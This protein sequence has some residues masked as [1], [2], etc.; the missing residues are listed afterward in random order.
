MKGK[1]TL[2][3]SFSYCQ[4]SLKY[5]VQVLRPLTPI[6]SP[7]NAETEESIRIIDGDWWMCAYETYF[8]DR[9]EGLYSCVKYLLIFLDINFVIF[10][11]AGKDN[12]KEPAKV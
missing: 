12:F 11:S 10:I 4:L 8:A 9:G 5:I 3:N 6:F 2:T 1:H 7:M